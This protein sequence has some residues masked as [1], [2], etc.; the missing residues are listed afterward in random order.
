[1]LDDGWTLEVNRTATDGAPNACSFLLGACWRAARAL[2]WR[3]L[4]TYT[5]ASE[6][7]TSLVAA[8]WRRVGEVSGR[9]W[10]RDSR[11][12][13]DLHPTQDKIKWEAGP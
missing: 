6:P 3:R 5:L 9:S 8:G 10:H 7:G 2:G 1:M 4:V 12:R 11:P 13:V